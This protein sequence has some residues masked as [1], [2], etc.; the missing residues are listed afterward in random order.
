M[1]NLQ[2]FDF[3]LHLV[4]RSRGCP[5]TH[6]RPD[7]GVP[8]LAI[9]VP[10]FNGGGHLAECLERLI[11]AVTELDPDGFLIAVFDDAS[12]DGSAELA[13]SV[14]RGR[15]VPYL[16]GRWSRNGGEAANC[17]QAFS[18]LIK[19]GFEW[20]L[21]AHQDD[22]QS[23][24]W[25][26]AV[27]N[28]ISR[29]DSDVG[30]ITCRNIGFRDGEQYL[31]DERNGS[32]TPNDR[33]LV[34]YFEGGTEGL[35]RFGDEWYW[36]PNG[37]VFRLRFF[38]YVGGFLAGIR[39][40]GDNDYI[41]RHFLSGGGVLDFPNVF[42]GHRLH[43]SSS[44]SRAFDQGNDAWGFGYILWKHTASIDRRVAT[45]LALKHFVGAVRVFIRRLFERRWQAA[46]GRLIAGRHYASCFLALLA[47]SDRFLTREIRT[48]AREG[49]TAGVTP[50]AVDDFLELVGYDVS[51]LDPKGAVDGL[52]P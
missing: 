3:V 49:R 48:L 24:E 38:T 11:A 9:V 44:T 1:K 15:G 10:S 14:L 6:G 33:R 31:V 16:V 30:A 13:L 52:A 34:R 7:G 39:F 4:L 29:A 36:L 23:S 47:R 40:A 50:D 2:E 46:L 45:R 8:I 35:K 51:L 21:L 32:I 25:L 17:N 42:V 20:A 26:I 19:R 43:Q 22:L 28:A 12:T 27:R 41:A 5:F 37:T 18:F